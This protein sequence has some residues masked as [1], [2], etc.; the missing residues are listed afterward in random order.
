MVM[1]SSSNMLVIENGVVFTFWSEV[2]VLARAV[3]PLTA[4][5][6]KFCGPPVCCIPNRALVRSRKLWNRWL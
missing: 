2:I 5:V 1:L 6:V 3:V 4:G